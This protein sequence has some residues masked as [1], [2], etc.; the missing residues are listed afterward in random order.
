[1][2]SATEYIAPRNEAESKLAAIWEEVLEVEQVGIQ[3]NFFE[4]GG[5]SL[6][7]IQVASRIHRELD[8]EIPLR[9][10]FNQPTIEE[11]AA[12]I[13]GKQPAQYQELAKIDESELLS[14]EDLKRIQSLLGEGGDAL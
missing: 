4:L 5:H 11:M 1:M 12:I 9:D 10:I 7:A 3:D 14:N 6:K 2:G 8:V 13:Q